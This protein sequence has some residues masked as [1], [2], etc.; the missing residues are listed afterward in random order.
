MDRISQIL[1]FWFEG[2]DDGTPIDP[3]SNPFKKWFVK[4][5]A[6]DAQVRKN[7]ENDLLSAKRGQL[8]DREKTGQGR[9]ALILLFD[10][11]SRN[12]YRGTPEMFE[13]DSKALDL[14]LRSIQEGMDQELAMIERVFLYMPLQHAED[15]EIQKLS[16]QHFGSLAQE[17]KEKNPRH[18]GYYAY[19]LDYAKRH[20]DIIERFGRFPHRN[21]I[22]GRASTTEELEF[23]QKPGSSF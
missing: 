2:I 5:P 16:L 23:L 20:Q 6:F 4:D 13:N 15:F 3:K 7:F 9:L 10:Q 8:R 18:A 14:T 11:F 21:P 22:L 12:I 1:Q 17:A 19:T